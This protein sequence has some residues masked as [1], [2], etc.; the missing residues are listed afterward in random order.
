MQQAIR[1]GIVALVIMAGVA[2][3]AYAQPAL[4]ESVDTLLEYA[5][6]H[7]PDYASMRHEA[8]AAN[9]RIVPAGALPDPRLQVELRDITRMGTQNPTLSTSRVRS[10]R[11]LL[12]QDIPWFGKRDLKREIAELE[13]AGAKGRAIGSWTELAS[14]IKT[15]YAQLYYIHRNRQLSEEILELISQLEKIAQVRYA[16]GLTAQQ[17]VIRAQM[18]KTSIQSEIVML[19]NE[20]VQAR[21]RMNAFLARPQ[22]A[23]LADPSRLRPLPAPVK[24]DYAALEERVRARNPQIFSE[25][26]RMKA[27]EKNRDLTYKNRYPDFSVGVSPIQYGNSIKEWELMFSINIPLQQSTRRSQERE[28][29]SMLAAARS[30]KDAAVNT[31]LSDLSSNLSGLDAIRRVEQLT[32][33]SLLPQANL[34][35]QSALASYENG[36]VDFATVMD[37]QKQIR[38]AKQSLIKAQ[39]EGQMRL[40]ELERLMGDEL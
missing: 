32:E 22:N 18:E 23:P 16:G 21:N 28:A 24:L 25:D 26:A 14:R 12:M 30:R 3:P 4:G 1:A 7:N 40:A 29:E 19:E 9:E 6:T 33:T 17:D 38:I 13:A 37:A 2:G 20:L 5:K 11:Y 34:T 35:L 8:D 39:A 10:T 36:K 27:A 31:V 15:N